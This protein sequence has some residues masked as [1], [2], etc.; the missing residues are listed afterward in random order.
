[1]FANK[2]SSQ[3]KIVIKMS[4]RKDSCAS[5]QTKRG[6]LVSGQSFNSS[7]RYFKCQC[8]ANY[9]P[10]CWNRKT[11]C[12]QDGTGFA[13]DPFWTMSKC[14]KCCPNDFL[15][16]CPN[17]MRTDQQPFLCN[18]EE[19]CCWNKSG[20]SPFVCKTCQADHLE[21]YRAL[22]EE[23]EHEEADEWTPG[24]EMILA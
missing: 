3:K 1:M 6:D 14:P 13:N 4:D 21:Q 23:E 20:K 22:E 10:G 11:D 8:G 19:C 15:V 24:V 12:N 16:K 17:C 7:H 5:C 2:F 18:D 9:C